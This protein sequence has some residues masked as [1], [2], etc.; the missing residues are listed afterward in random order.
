[1]VSGTGGAAVV[2]CVTVKM[3]VAYDDSG[4]A[5]MD[6][7]SANLPVAAAIVVLEILAVDSGSIGSDS[8]SRR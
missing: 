3:V 1:M 8:S 5:Y 6:T 2:S 7:I 4:V